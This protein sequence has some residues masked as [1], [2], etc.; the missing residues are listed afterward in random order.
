MHR[1]SL[2]F[3]VR[4]SHIQSTEKHNPLVPESL[5]DFRT[6][7][8]LPTLSSEYYFQCTHQGREYYPIRIYLWGKSCDVSTENPFIYTA[9][10]CNISGL[11]KFSTIPLPV[12][13]HK[14]L[15][16][17]LLERDQIQS[18]DPYT[19]GSRL[20]SPQPQQCLHSPRSF[21][22]FYTALCMASG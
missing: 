2:H 13:S 12:P 9:G 10:S 11:R 20:V 15:D 18:T 19:G 5:M 16:L 14:H 3:M 21:P 7:V 8:I 4:I 6:L 1:F 17:P 22:S